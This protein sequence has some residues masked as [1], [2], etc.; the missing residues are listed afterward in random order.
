MLPEHRADAYVR[1]IVDGEACAVMAARPG[2]RHNTL[3]AAARTLGRLVGGGELAEATA[4][5][6][7]QDASAVHIGVDGC[8]LREVVRTIDDGIAYGKRLPRQIAR[9][10]LGQ[11]PRTDIPVAPRARLLVARGAASSVHRT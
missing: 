7:L 5:A 10:R 3:L 6:V 9:D 1:A 2:T 11:A 4:R 8:T